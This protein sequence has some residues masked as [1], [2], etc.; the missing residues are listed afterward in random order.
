MMTGFTFYSDTMQ[1]ISMILLLQLGFQ[2]CHFIIRETSFNALQHLQDKQILSPTPV[3]SCVGG[4]HYTLP[5]SQVSGFNI[6]L[7]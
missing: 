2:K 3:S 4:E 7:Y 1:G 6:F 5:V